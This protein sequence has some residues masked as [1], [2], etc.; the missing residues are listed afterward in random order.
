MIK[1]R[2]RTDIKNKAVKKLL[3]AGVPIGKICA[4]FDCGHVLIYHIRDGLLA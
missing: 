2:Y 4:H 3:D 1:K